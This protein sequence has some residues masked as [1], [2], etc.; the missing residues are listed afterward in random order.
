LPISVV[1]TAAMSLD[2]SAS[3][4][5]IRFT[6]AARSATDFRDHCS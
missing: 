3:S 6:T 1:I 2:R 5:E 4:S